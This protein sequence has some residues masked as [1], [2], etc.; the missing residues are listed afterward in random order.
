MG[1]SISLTGVAIDCGQVGGLKEIYIAPVEDVT[2]TIIIADGAVDTVPLA[3]GKKFKL[4]AF[5]K[6]NANFV[7]TGNVD[8]AAG[9]KYVETVLTAQL[10]KMETAKRTEMSA[11]MA[12]QVYVIA[13]DY[14]GLYWF[15][16]YGGYGYGN[17]NGQ[18]GAQMGDANS[19][20]LTITAQTPDLPYVV[21][22]SLLSGV[23]SII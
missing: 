19:Y 15:I 8:D 12:S 10:N 14:N 13:K 3:S 20:T 17:V 7:S 23:G 16:G 22:S 11:I 9:T 5:R 6:G 2:G 21:K 4:F 18:S 1:C